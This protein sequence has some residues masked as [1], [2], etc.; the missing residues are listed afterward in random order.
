MTNRQIQQVLAVE[1]GLA[2]AGGLFEIKEETVLGTTLPVFTKRQPSLRALLERSRDYGE[3]IYIISEQER[4][5]YG[6]HFAR[7]APL[8]RALQQE[9]GVQKGDH[10]A[11]LAANCPEW[12]LSFWAAANLGA[13]AVALN[14][15]WSGEELRYALDDAKPKVLLGDGKRLSRLDIA[16]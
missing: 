1:R 14:G 11:I 9:F 13:V 7:V 15:W 10:V 2:R 5:S 16:P 3:K 12:I 6:E 8:A 4:I